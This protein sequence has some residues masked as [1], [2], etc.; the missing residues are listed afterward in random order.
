MIVSSYGSS[1]RPAPRAEPVGEIL[2]EWVYTLD[3][4]REAADKNGVVIACV[5]WTNLPETCN[6][7]HSTVSDTTLSPASLSGTQYEM[8]SMYCGVP[9]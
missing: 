5:A 4:E 1:R 6:L 2:R 7:Y 8:P 3:G 9:G